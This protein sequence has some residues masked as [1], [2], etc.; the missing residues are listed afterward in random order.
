MATLL[1]ALELALSP[2]TEPS[3]PGGDQA[4]VQRD[5]ERRSDGEHGDGD[6]AFLGHRS[7]LM[8]DSNAGGV[9]RGLVSNALG[10]VSTLGEDA[11][12]LA[13]E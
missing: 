6:P 7:Q 2:S 3:A 11:V 12:P 8:D 1:P 5:L 4:D 9:G 13:G 10:A